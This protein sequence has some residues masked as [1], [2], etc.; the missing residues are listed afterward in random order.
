MSRKA[1]KE[2]KDKKKMQNESRLREIRQVLA[3]N[4][5][6]RGVTPEKLRIILEEL[7]PTYIKLGQIMSLHSDILPKEYCDELMKLN[8]DVV[9]M[10]FETVE[11]VINRSYRCDW[12]DYFRSIEETPLGSASIAQVHRAV[13][14]DG[15][16]VVIKVQRKGIYDTMARD[17]SLLHRLVSL[18]PPVASLKNLVDLNMVLDEMWSVAQE[19]MDFLK[20][21]SNMEEFARNN[22][23]IAYVESPRLYHEY[24]TSRVLVMEYIDGW[25]IDDVADLK[26]NGYDLEEIGSRFVNN[27]IKQVMDDG[28]FHADPHPGNVKIR[29]GRIVWIDMG[30]MGRLTERDR[31]IMVKGVRG[32]AM[33]DVTQVE[34]AVLELCDST[35]TPDRVRL[36]ND[37]KKFLDQYGAA[38]M[39]SIDVP[40]VVQN[41]MDIMKVNHLRVPHGVSMLARGLTHMQGVLTKISPDINMFEIAAARVS[42]DY[43]RHIDWKKEIGRNGRVL[44]RSA[45]K[46]AEIPSLLTDVLK[47]Y[48]EGSSKVGVDLVATESLMETLFTSVRNLVIGMCIAALLISSS[49]LCMTDMKPKILGIPA[50]GFVGYAIAVA[51]GTFVLGRYIVNKIRQARGR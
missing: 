39:G 9:P 5:I 46:G 45:T 12:H 33:R 30:M 32:I 27:Y 43:L 6:T 8:S 44:Y 36:Y 17:I 21:A 16:D 29:D 10:P 37:L 50:L 25:P 15:S 3:R 2:E 28:F 7:G 4:H 20:E 40:E 35:G 42:E 34:N 48:L 22:K 51:A 23:G 19:E 13:L 11:E 49:V 24:T 31:R 1:K 14:K 41:L 47:E 18:M 26:A 38:G